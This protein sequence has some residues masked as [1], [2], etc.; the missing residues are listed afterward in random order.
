[1]AEIVLGSS[2]V[3]NAGRTL[4]TVAPSG[5]AI[6][7]TTGPGE[8]VGGTAVALP[9]MLTMLAHEFTGAPVEKRTVAPAISVELS[10]DVVSKYPVV[11]KLLSDVALFQ[12]TP[13]GI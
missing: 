7:K 12:V 1:M 5:I 9:F 11:T 3:R 4:T 13:D 8:P 2:A 10:E 6:D